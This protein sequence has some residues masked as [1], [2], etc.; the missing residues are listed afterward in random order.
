MKR[1][2]Q[3]RNHLLGYLNNHP[4]RKTIFGVFLV[5]GIIISSALLY[6]STSQFYTPYQNAS[7]H[8]K[9]IT[10]T[11]GL[12]AIAARQAD[13]TPPQV[14]IESPT[15]GTVLTRDNQQ[16]ISVVASDNMHLSRIDIWVDSLLLKTCLG[17]TSCEVKVQVNG[18]A[19]GDHI[20]KTTAKD[21][22]DNTSTA[23]VNVSK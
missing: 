7:P 12:T 5:C 19:P 1:L 17:K 20:I 21:S 22:N 9:R 16:Q 2:I 4:L 14:S 15:E 6:L 11:T 23:Q 10:N 13:V 18:L 3:S 8:S